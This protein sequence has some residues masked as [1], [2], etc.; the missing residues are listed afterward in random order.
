MK[1]LHPFQQ[2]RTP[3][4]AIWTL[5]IL[6]LCAKKYSPKELLKN[7]KFKSDL[8]GLIN[9][10]LKYVAGIAARKQVFCSE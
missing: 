5:E 10:R 9:D 6:N 4:A 3:L 2:A 7:E 1:A 8:H